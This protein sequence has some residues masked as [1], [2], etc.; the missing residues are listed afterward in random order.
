M[1]DVLIENGGNLNTNTLPDFFLWALSQ[2]NSLHSF[3]N[4]NNCQQSFFP[5]STTSRMFY[6]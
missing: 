5:D 1:A 4:Q 3:Q 2:S 6:E